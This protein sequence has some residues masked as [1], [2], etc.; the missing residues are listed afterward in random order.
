MITEEELKK[1]QKLAK[2]SFSKDELYNFAKEI[3]TVLASRVQMPV[4]HKSSISDE[5]WKNIKK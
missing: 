2:L 3:S 5:D 1:L 4:T